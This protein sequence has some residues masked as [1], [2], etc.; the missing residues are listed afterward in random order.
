[1][2]IFDSFQKK[3]ALDIWLFSVLSDPRES[4]LPNSGPLSLESALLFSRDCFLFMLSLCFPLSPPPLSSVRFVS[5]FNHFRADHHHHHDI[6]FGRVSRQMTCNNIRFVT[7]E[8]EFW[9]TSDKEVWWA[10]LSSDSSQKEHFQTLGYCRKLEFWIELNL[11]EKWIFLKFWV[12]GLEFCLQ[13][14][15]QGNFLK[16]R[17]KILIL[18]SRNFSEIFWN[19]KR[20]PL[21][22]EKKFRNF[23][24]WPRN[25]S[26]RISNFNF[27]LDRF[28]WSAFALHL[29]K[30]CFAL[31]NMF[32][33]QVPWFFCGFRP[34]LQE[35]QFGFFFFFFKKSTWESS[36]CL[37]LL[38]NNGLTRWH[39]Q[40][41]TFIEF[42]AGE[43]WKNG[44]V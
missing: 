8:E 19:C 41:E 14:L 28:K 42:W 27:P 10:I 32:F 25:S 1:M 30:T 38:D 35:Q 43:K 9:D 33:S 7:N 11:D 44:D 20:A 26:S 29:E 5:N 40:K 15:G 6:S 24:F 4:A 21:H 13:K 12:I 39:T 17:K 23:C 2:L 37:F 16:S 18:N 22:S 36:F 34:L 31:W 3:I